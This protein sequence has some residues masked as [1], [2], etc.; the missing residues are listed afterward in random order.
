VESVAPLLQLIADGIAQNLDLQDAK[1]RDANLRNC[2]IAAMRNGTHAVKSS[3]RA[4]LEVGR[5]TLKLK[6]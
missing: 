3:K 6:C 1:A 2:N 5:M 4:G